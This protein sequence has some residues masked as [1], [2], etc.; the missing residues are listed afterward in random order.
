M[1]GF[2]FLSAEKRGVKRERQLVAAGVVM[3]RG[4]ARRIREQAVFVN[5]AETIAAL[6][7]EQLPGDGLRQIQPEILIAL[8]RHHLPVDRT[9]ALEQQTCGQ[10]R[11]EILPARNH[12]GAAAQAA[13][14][15][16]RMRG[17]QLERQQRVARTGRAEQRARDHDRGGAPVGQREG[18]G[19]CVLGIDDGG[20]C[21]VAQARAGN[22][23]E[24]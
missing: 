7:K 18:A 20:A 5:H 11:T 8:K 13:F 24:A 2:D 17:A 10:Q 22:R 14:E 23:R 4:P 3:R 15:C 19:D 9:V 1:H 21:D 16:E 12:F 6:I